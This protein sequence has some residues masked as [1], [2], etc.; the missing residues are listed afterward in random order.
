M[1]INRAIYRHS[2]AEPQTK[3]TDFYCVLV[4]AFN[5]KAAIKGV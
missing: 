5:V 1:N 4:S 2:A 3:P